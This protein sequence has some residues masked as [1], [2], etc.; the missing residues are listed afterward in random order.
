MLVTSDFVIRTMMK[1][2]SLCVCIGPEHSRKQFNFEKIMKNVLY[3]KIK[4]PLATAEF[5]M[6]LYQNPAPIC[7]Q[8]SFYVC[9]SKNCKH[10][11]YV[12]S[13][14]WWNGQ[15]HQHQLWKNLRGRS[16]ERNISMRAYD[17]TTKTIVEKCLWES[18]SE[19]NKAIPAF[20]PIKGRSA[21]WKDK[22]AR[23]NGEQLAR[24]T[25]DCELNNV[26]C[27]KNMCW[28]NCDTRLYSADWCF[29][30]KNVSMRNG[31]KSNLQHVN[32]IATV[33]LV[34]RA[35]SPA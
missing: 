2:N 9:R 19:K 13:I 22:I 18:V 23:N 35:L 26:G 24:R 14:V 27:I 34:G 6:K 29:V 8:C 1:D 20:I 16:E 21:G 30:T 28:S 3:I 7:K 10:F 4:K 17:S 31:K 25:I 11:S 12:I 15:W 33:N 5:Y 32:E